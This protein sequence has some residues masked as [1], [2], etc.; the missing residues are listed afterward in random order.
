MVGE[1]QVT[2][3]SSGDYEENPPLPLS[4]KQRQQL[5]QLQ[6]VISTS[7]DPQG[8]LQQAAESNGMSAAELMNMLEKNARD[9]QQDPTLIQPMTIP[10]AIIRTMASI[11]M[12][13]LKV[14]KSNPRSFSLAA[15]A[16]L[17]IIYTLI[18][19]P[20]T[21]LHVSTSRIFILSSG[22]TTIFPPPQRYLHKLISPTPN[23][24]L[25]DRRG[26]SIKTLKKE[27]DDLTLDDDGVH[28]HTLP[29]K[30]ELGQA[31]T[32]QFSLS[33]DMLLEEFSLGE[34]EEQITEERHDIVDL[35]YTSSKQLL[36]ERQ[37]VEFSSSD[38]DGTDQSI[39]SVANTENNMGILVVPGL[40]NFGRHGLV[41][42]KATH[43]S[44]SEDTA[45][46]TLTTLK[47][48][49]F[50][51]GQIHIAAMKIPE[52]DGMIQVRVSLAV[53]K[54]GRTI[55]KTTGQK[56]VQ[57]MADA[58]VKSCSRRTKQILARKSQGRRFKLSASR[59]ANA[60]RKTRFDREKLLE[61]M[62]ED[63][64]RRWQRSNPDAGR[65]R[66]SGHR[67]R[68]PNNC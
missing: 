31:I 50:F 51:D 35:L 6:Q 67:Q 58:I 46:V 52:E 4:M 42:W 14:A 27:W 63:R 37:F 43:Q 32:A 22:P 23:S 20:R 30:N 45:T 17:L 8:T 7:P 38:Y 33:P 61:Q 49:G 39:R 59:R 44:E 56:I 26:L 24:K 9:L 11:G 47:G 21:G 15:L 66:P 12:V 28:V 60:R 2:W 53:P 5:L 13:V 54:G 34:T 25:V 65:Y 16:M 41:F 68:S 40:G 64:R 55:S 29:R 19:V 57:E 1:E 18:E 3:T 36:S 48:M 10:K 62:A